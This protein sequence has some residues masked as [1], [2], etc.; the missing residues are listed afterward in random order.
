MGTR[1]DKC[2]ELDIRLTLPLRTG[3][4]QFRAGPFGAKIR[5][6]W[7]QQGAIE[8][9]ALIVPADHF[10]LSSRIKDCRVG[11]LDPHGRFAPSQCGRGPRRGDVVVVLE[12]PHYWEYGYRPFRPLEPLR[13]SRRFFSENIEEVLRTYE[14][15]PRANDAVVLCNPVPFQASLARFIR[16]HLNGPVRDGV[17][18]LLF[19]FLRD[20][21]SSR[22]AA[23]EPRLVIVACTGNLAPVV[24]NTL[25]SVRWE[26]VPPRIRTTN[27]PSAWRWNVV[28]D[29]P[30][31]PR[32]SGARSIWVHLD[33]DLPS[34]PWDDQ[35]ENLRPHA[36]GYAEHQPQH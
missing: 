15:L 28:Y 7:C 2:M 6:E 8:D 35:W 22:I 34:D 11:R 17:W 33:S 10:V 30:A 36:R 32:E 20:Q 18:E 4:H 14:Y 29:K 27:H 21:F 31:D 26:G 16:G 25:G 23:L 9:G 1:Q 13:H 19:Y 24:M 12:S 3:P 5:E